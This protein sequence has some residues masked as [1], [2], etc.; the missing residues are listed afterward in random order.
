[1]KINKIHSWYV[2]LF[3][4]CVHLNLVYS[5][6]TLN[7]YNHFISASANFQY[8]IFGT[9]NHVRIFVALNFVMFLLVNLYC[10]L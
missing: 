10:A 4:T 3:Q 2:K 7:L 5:N 1:M 8:H 6:K 9:L